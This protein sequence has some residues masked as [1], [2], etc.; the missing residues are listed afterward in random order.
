MRPF[1]Y[2]I[3]VEAGKHRSRFVAYR[4]RQL[5]EINYS[6]LKGRGILETSNLPLFRFYLLDTLCLLSLLSPLTLLQ[7]IAPSYPQG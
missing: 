1:W 7:A 4:H 2:I 5:V 6:S 3:N